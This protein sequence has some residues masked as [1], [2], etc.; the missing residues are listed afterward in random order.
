MGCLRLPTTDTKGVRN[1]MGVV[2]LLLEEEEQLF[3]QLEGP[4]MDLRTCHPNA[5]KLPLKGFC[6]FVSMCLLVCH[7]FLSASIHGCVFCMFLD[8]WGERERGGGAWVAQLV[9]SLTLD[10]SSGCDLV[11]HEVEPCIGI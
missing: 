3:W 6:D 4:S 10:F 1:L 5:F 8:R 2:P 11:V 7:S 9:Q